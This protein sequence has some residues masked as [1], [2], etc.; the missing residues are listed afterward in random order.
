M[1]GCATGEEVYSLAIALLETA[2]AMNSSVP[3]Q[4]FGTDVSET[5]IERA[6]AGL[7]PESISADVRQ[8]IFCDN[9]RA[10]FGI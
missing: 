4:I 9:A 3:I 8:K 2:S 5:A 10:L 7:Y 1:P 6:R